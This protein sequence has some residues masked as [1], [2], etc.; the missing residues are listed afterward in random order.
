MVK[1]LV[2][3]LKKSDKKVIILCAADTNVAVDNLLEGMHDLGI[4]A[5]R[6]GK[7]VKIREEL[8]DLSLDAKLLD[9]SENGQLSLLRYQRDELI[10]KGHAAGLSVIKQN[11]KSIETR[12]SKDVMN[13][14][15]VIC[16]TCIGAAAELLEDYT[17]PVVLIDGK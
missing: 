7:P 8:R 4:K 14:V 2:H 17:F 3:C 1:L 10:R 13:D 6:V 9:H 12:M 5:L 16:S 15:D 11:I